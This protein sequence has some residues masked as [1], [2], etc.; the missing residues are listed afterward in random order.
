MS[1]YTIAQ[2]SEE[3]ELTPYTLRY[4]EKEGLLPNVIKDSAGRR[5]YRDDD[6]QRIGFIKLSLIHI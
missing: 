3:V 2:A 6:L 1:L 4:Y 5:K